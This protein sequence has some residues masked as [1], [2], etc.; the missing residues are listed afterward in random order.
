VLSHVPC[1]LWS[2][3]LGMATRRWREVLILDLQFL[4][5]WE[6]KQVFSG[7]PRAVELA[8][9]SLQVDFP[10]LFHSLLYMGCNCHR[11]I[12]SRS[13]PSSESYIQNLHSRTRCF[14]FAIGHQCPVLDPLWSSHSLPAVWSPSSTPSC[15]SWL[16]HLPYLPCQTI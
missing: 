15:H 7:R 9:S 1:Q 10:S 3:K 11:S 14:A 16:H 12:L 13:G 4:A 8:E 2:A 6:S 5:A